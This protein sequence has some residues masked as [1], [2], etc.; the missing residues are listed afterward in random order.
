MR[1]TSWVISVGRWIGRGK[2]SG[3]EVKGR[4]ASAFRFRDGKVVEYVLGFPSKEAAVE[5]VR[6]RD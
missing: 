3:A 5:F 1:P 6:L 4:A 2:E